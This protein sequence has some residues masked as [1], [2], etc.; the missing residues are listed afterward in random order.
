MA[1]DVISG[2]CACGQIRF[3]LTGTP[4]KV[5]ACHCTDCQKFTGG[6]A[7][8]HMI[9]NAANLS[10]LQG[11]P[12]HFKSTAD[13]GSDVRRHFCG[14]CGAPLWSE[15]A[16]RPI[17]AIKVAALEPTGDLALQYQIYTSSAPN[18]HVFDPDVP[19]FEKMAPRKG[20]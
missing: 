9:Y 7:N 20:N 11:T 10:I 12:K 19:S 18:W 14:D 3:Q 8:V 6:N 15:L 16:H 17:I 13:S 4:E 2:Q 5:G 1:G